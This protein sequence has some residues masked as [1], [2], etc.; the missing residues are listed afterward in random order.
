MKKRFLLSL[1]VLIILSR[2]YYGQMPP[3]PSL[4]DK[5]KQ[6]VQAAPYLLSNINLLRDKGIDKPWVKIFLQ[7]P[8]DASNHTMYTTI[9]GVIPKT[10]PYVQDPRIVSEIPMDALDWVLVQLRASPS[11]HAVISK[12]IFL[13]K[14]G[15]LV[16]DD[17]ITQNILLN[18]AS[19]SYY[20]VIVHRNHLSVMSAAA[21]SLLNS[22]C[23]VYDFTTAQTQAYGTNPMIDLGDGKFGMYAG[24]SNNDGQ[25]TTLDYNLWLPNARVSLTGYT[26]TDINLDGQNTTLD[27]NLWLPNARASRSSQ[28]P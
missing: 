18:A 27:Y 21:V 28:V 9:N 1:F 26:I 11:S 25:I 15:N 4:L 2:N 13:N 6:G 8:Y 24:D 17:G 3:H 20:I 5:I 14:D 7:G 19:G 22:A 23:T 12:S 10:S 16:A